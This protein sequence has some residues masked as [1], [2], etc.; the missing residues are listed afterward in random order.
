MNMPSR[1]KKLEEKLDMGNGE[2]LPPPTL[3]IGLSTAYRDEPL[4]DFPEDVSQWVA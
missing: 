4:L 2:P 3:C 1:L